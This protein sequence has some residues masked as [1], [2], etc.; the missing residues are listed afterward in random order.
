[1]PEPT[2]T[3]LEPGLV[4][5]TMPLPWALDHV[6]CYALA[7][8]DG[9]TLVDAG[10]GSEATLRWWTQ[11]LAQLGPSPVARLVLTHYHPD[12]VGASAG[13][14]E[15]SGAPEVV[16]G[17]L[18]RAMAVAAWWA[19]TCCSTRSPP[20]GAAGR[21]P[22]ATRWVAT[23]PRCSGCRSWRRGPSSPATGP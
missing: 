9:W 5:I 3:E 21:T 11:A 13:L 4:Q 23:W 22:L 18:D 7:G 17:R 19:A 12:H 1:M 16:Q 2:L 15:L 10:L 8:T 20:T 6:H 14:A